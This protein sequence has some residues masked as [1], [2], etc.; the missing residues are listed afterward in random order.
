MMPRQITALPLW[1]AMRTPVEDRERGVALIMVIG[2]GAVVTALI[3]TAVIFTVGGMRHARDDVDW[4][5]ALA[6]AYAG[7]EEYQSR[8]AENPDYVRFG[9]DDAPFSA[10]SSLLEDT[11]NPAL[12]FG[13][14]WATVPGSVDGASFRYEVD[15]SAYYSEGV[16]RVRSTG[17]VGEETRSIVADL[18]QAGFVHY[19]YF[20]DREI[21][22]PALSSYGSECYRYAWS[23]PPRPSNSS[24]PNDRCGIIT[25]ASSDVINGQVHS[26]DIIYA[27]GT[28]FKGAVTTS[29]NPSSGVRYRCVGAGGTPTFEVRDAQRGNSPSYL[30]VLG[31]PETN[32]QIRAAALESG[33]VYTGPTSIRLLSNG[34]MTVRSPLTRATRPGQSIPN[35][36][37]CGA[38]SQ[39]ASSVGATVRVPDSG[40]VYVQNVP[41]TA[42]DPNYRARPSGCASGNGLG[43]PVSNERSPSTVASV[44]PYDCHSGDLFVQGA[45][46]GQVTLAA[47]N[48]IYITGNTTYVDPD[49]DMLGLIGNNMVYVRNPAI[50]TCTGSGWWETCSTRVDSPNITIDA[51]ILSLRSFAVQN[52]GVTGDRDGT[53]TVR[54]SI[55]QA[56][57][58]VVAY[59]SGYN[60]DYVYDPRLRFRSPPHFLSPVTS[61]YGVS[62]WIETEPAI[63]AEGSWR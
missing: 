25:F 20:T 28:T 5:G 10:G 7:V 21:Q 33:C 55:A 27:C 37:S 6:A 22:D 18:R 51:A 26:N 47:E 57:R 62:T 56:F 32:G 8:L 63:D 23:N 3:A 14:S 46:N 9:N 12:G 31:M 35:P 4:N 16:L 29:W 45:L 30:P 11:S 42:G 40:A 41:G 53:L 54:G 13:S 38:P 24:R 15:T 44:A 58:G 2:I 43:Y 48:F 17:R 50:E 52:T 61:A 1:R 19:L 34:D 59:Q 49:D 60:K 36:V 39:L